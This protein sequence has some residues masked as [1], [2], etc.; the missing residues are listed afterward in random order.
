MKV[1]HDTIMIIGYAQYAIGLTILKRR[2]W[3]K[4]SDKAYFTVCI[5]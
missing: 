5:Q 1:Y 4:S 2:V 3:Q